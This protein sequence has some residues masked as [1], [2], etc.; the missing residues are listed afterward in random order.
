MNGKLT[1][2]EFC[3]WFGTAA[4]GT[5][6]AGP[7][8]FGA[9]NQTA[10]ADEISPLFQTLWLPSLAAN[11]TS[12]RLLQDR[13]R[14]GESPA[15]VVLRGES[16]VSPH[17]AAAFSRSLAAFGMNPLI[18]VDSLISRFHL[19]C[20]VVRPTRH[21]FPE[22]KRGMERS[23]LCVG[24]ITLPTRTLEQIAPNTL[25][26]LCDGLPAMILFLDPARG[27]W[28]CYAAVRDFSAAK[29]SPPADHLWQKTDRLRLARR[30]DLAV[31]APS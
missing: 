25:A 13:F 10:A 2:R 21:P 19:S 20:S 11:P 15:T 5:V 24:S 6:T 3:A 4:V 9:E 22:G 31:K 17:N 8:A 29:N 14:R 23:K 18:R 26:E 30:I 12:L 28:T 7:L 1:R 16:L 27:V